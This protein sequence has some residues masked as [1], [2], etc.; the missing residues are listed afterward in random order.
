MMPANSVAT[1]VLVDASVA[2]YQSFARGV[3]P[4]TEVLTIDPH[5]DGIAQISAILANYPQVQDVQIVSHG[6]P[7]CLYLG[8]TRLADDTLSRYADQIRQWAMALREGARLVFYGC[9]VAAGEVG[10]RFVSAIAQLTQT[11]VVASETITGNSEQGGNWELEFTTAALP[12]SD[13][14]TQ[15][16]QPAFLATYAGTFAYVSENLTT[17]TPL[18]LANLLK[19]QGITIVSATTLTTATVAA[20]KFAFVDEPSP[21][22][23]QSGVI[24]SSGNIATAEGPNQ[25]TGAGTALGTPGSTELSS[26]IGNATTNDA[27]F[28]EIKFIPETSAIGLTFVFASEEYT[29]FSFSPF[30]DVF[31]FFLNGT[32]IANLPGQAETVPVSI[33]NVNQSTN[34][35][36]FVYNDQRP[37]P[38]NTE[39]DG[40]T[41]V[42]RIQAEVQ[43]GVENTLTFAIAD[44]TDSI[45]DSAVFLE[46]AS[47]FAIDPNA[48]ILVQPT[49]GLVTTEAGGTA[50]FSVSLATQPFANVSFALS[51]SDTTEGVINVNTLTFTPTNWNVPQTVTITGVPDGIPDGDVFYS[52][53]TGTATSTDRNYN[54]KKPANVSV[55]NRDIDG[56]PSLMPSPVPIAP[57][58]PNPLVPVAGIPVP[59][60]ILFPPDVTIPGVLVPPSGASELINGTEQA[61]LIRG[62]DGNDTI[63][64]LGGNDTLLGNRGSD[65]LNGGE[66]DDLLR[67]GK[68]NDVLNGG[69]GNDFLYG[70]RG[71]DLVSGENGDDLIYGGKDN[72]TLFGGAGND[73]LFGDL[74]SDSLNGGD[75]NDTL[76]GAGLRGTPPGAGE[77]DT[78]TGGAG[79]DLFVLGDATQL[80]YRDGLNGFALITDFSNLEDRIQLKAGID[81]QITGAPAGLPTGAAIF[82]GTDLIA[83]VANVAPSP[84]LEARFSLV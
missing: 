24:L 60:L 18:M 16:F 32:N 27:A 77:R 50:S 49:A 6:C 48:A 43:A 23:I 45:L 3:I 61:D 75:G 54:G 10:R 25:A 7:G 8:S 82:A 9:Q 72:D 55:V 15:I 81:Y 5:Q 33:R 52:I 69:N 4:G 79:A 44:T 30:N 31:A 34:T 29:E 22:G 47:L 64:G 70:D 13:P 38:F 83:I 17:Q 59:P 35:A 37:G 21:V 14:P 51:S 67:G 53:L 57:L 19:S 73:T 56:G 12:L 1:L 39:F 74:D 80:Y 63:N 46:E 2:Y 26:L 76:I 58:I 41:V 36:F 11:T 62:G 42:L 84:A 28:L 68:D 78:L 40:F 20:G 71:N 65:I 66:G